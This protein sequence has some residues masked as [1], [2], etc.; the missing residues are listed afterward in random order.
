MSKVLVAD[1]ERGICAA[2]ST[3]LEREGYEALYCQHR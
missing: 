2:L 1:D 3:V